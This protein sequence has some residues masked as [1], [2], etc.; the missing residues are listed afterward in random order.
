M[1]QVVSIGSGSA[2][3]P[4][5][6][7]LASFS[8]NPMSLLQMETAGLGMSSVILSMVVQKTIERNPIPG[9]SPHAHICLVRRGAVNVWPNDSDQYPKAGEKIE[10]RMPLVATTWDEFLKVA[11]EESKCAEGAVC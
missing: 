6:E 3:P 5:Q 11:S 1:G 4:Y 7:A 2:F 10:F 9:I 8:S